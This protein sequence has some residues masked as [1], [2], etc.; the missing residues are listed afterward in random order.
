[1]AAIVESSDDAILSKDLDG[2]IQSCN[3]A[4]QRIF[5]YTAAELIGRSVHTLIPEE[6]QP[7]EDDI[8]RRIRDGE[9]V[10]HFETVRIT[11]DQRCLDVSL[12]IS[13]VRDASGV[14]IG[15]SSIVRDITEQ[16]RARAT[17]AYLAAIVESSEDAILSKDL[18]GI[19]RSCNQTAERLF[20]YSASELIGRSIRVLIPPDK[21]AEEDHILATIRRGERIEHFETVRMT[22]DGR[23]LDISLSV[24]PVRDSSG[25]IVGVAKVVR[26]ITEQKRLA[27]ELA[28]QQEWFRVTL[29]SIGDGVVAN[30]RRR[31]CDVRER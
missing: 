13:P 2:V 7:E 17:Q 12:T 10:D 8:L 31:S 22:K 1:M 26:D 6:H 25:A 20:G 11:K 4:T 19:V 23:H 27:R 5:G 18:N 30:R 15:A 24:S 14:V 29:G 28:A 21:Q 9:R 16:K 3:P